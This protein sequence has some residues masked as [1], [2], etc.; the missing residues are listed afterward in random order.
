MAHPDFS[1]ATTLPRWIGWRAEHHGDREALVFV[2]DDQAE[3][4]WTY[5]ELWQRSCI[6]ADRLLKLN[7]SREGDIDH[8]APRALLLYPPGIEFMAGFLGCQIAGWIPVPTCYPK[9]GREMPRL[10]SAARDCDPSAIL[11]DRAAIEGIDPDKICE[12]ARAA[13]LVITGIDDDEMNAGILREPVFAPERMA[14][15]L[16][17]IS[18]DTIALLQYTSGSTSDPKGVMVR[19]RNVMANLEAIRVGFGIDWQV[20]DREETAGGVFWLPFFHDM[21]LIGG[22]LEPLYV[23]GRTVLM[24]P[25]SF[26]QRPLRWLQAISDYGAMIT[27]APNFAYQLCVDRISPEQTDK[28]DLSRWRIAFSGAEPVLP[29]TLN[30]FASRFA[31]CGFS[32]AAF[33]PCYGLAEATLLAAGGDGPGEPEFLTVDRESLGTGN[34]IVLA[35][36]R[37]AAFQKLVSCGTPSL[38]TE[39]AIVDLKTGLEVEPRT[40]GEIWLRGKSVTTGYWNRDEENAEQF[41]ASLADG[42]GGF[43]RTGD[44]GF[45]HEGQLYV[46]GRL[47]DVVILRGRNLFPQDIEATTRETIGPEGG[48]AA[49]FAIDGGRGEALA[50]VAELP[51]RFDEGGAA[52]L[53]RAIRRAVIDVHE[54]DPR[55]VWLVRQATVPLTSSGKIQRSRTREMFDASGDDDSILNVRYRYDRASAGEQI[56]ID[57]PRLPA[58]PTPDDHAAILAETE[59][60]MTQWLIARAGVAPGDV[61]LDKPF[62]DYGLDSMTAVEMS[63]EI[64][65]WS[66]VELT[67][68]VAWNYPTVSRLSEFI[69]QQIVGTAAEPDPTNEL[70]EAE[71][72][73]LLSEIEQL[74]DDEINHALADKRRP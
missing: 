24:S 2:A 16:A 67:P 54:V 33:Y 32:S 40:V 42:R 8:A 25:R 49:A 19:Q 66:D 72:D 17:A 12:A 27:G 53:V 9:P 70:S 58:D 46:T 15:L 64:E 28:L 45:V 18:P 21:G 7:A 52:D 26:L 50:I 35:G 68:I 36:G 74:S 62:A 63:G 59:S 3:T 14:E 11:G 22:I 13:T 38:G 55:S 65:D 5:A 61:D 69:A 23:G 60:W 4:T 71:L 73:G 34:P 39:L 29:R 44:L 30:D 56:P 20:H 10:D 43:A 51:R 37:G 6:V 1:A 48:Q 41:N 31:A 47:K 57:L